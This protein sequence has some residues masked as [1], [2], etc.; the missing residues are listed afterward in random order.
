MSQENVELVRRAFDAFNR[1]DLDAALALLDDNVEFGSR[2][3]GMEGGFHGH[4]GVRRWWQII[5]EASPDRIIEIVDA[6]A[7][8]DVT[9]TLARARGHGAVSQIPYEETA[10]SVARWRDKKATWWGVFPTRAEAL[11]AVGL[12]ESAPQRGENPESRA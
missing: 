5:R 7:L 6:R 12:S 8:G 3:A 10:W 11:E 2:L 4:R 1:R 9:L